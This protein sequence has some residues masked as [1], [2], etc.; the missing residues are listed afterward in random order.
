MSYE[1][2]PQTGGLVSDNGKESPGEHT[3]GLRVASLHRHLEY[4]MRGQRTWGATG[5]TKVLS[6]VG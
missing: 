3:V 6:Q 1:G 4:G 2:D 5:A